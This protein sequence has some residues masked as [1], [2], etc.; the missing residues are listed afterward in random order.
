MPYGPRSNWIFSFSN[1]FTVRSSDDR[2]LAAVLLADSS[3]FGAELGGDRLSLRTSD[4][5]GFGRALPRLARDAGIS[6]F[7]VTPTDE[8]LES[9]FSYLVRR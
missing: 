8:S 2:R 4:F 5:D 1:T 9:V 6:L 7:E 3:V